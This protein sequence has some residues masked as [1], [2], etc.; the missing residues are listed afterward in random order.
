MRADR[1]LSLLMLLQARGR[2]TA[3]ELAKKLE[4]SERTVY[5]DMSALGMAGVPV[6]SERGPGGGCGLIEGY[7][8]NLTGLTETEV[9][10]LFMAGAPALLNDLGLGRS[11]EG[12]VLKLLAALPAA[13]RENVERARQRIH[14]DAFGWSHSEE[15]VP[16]LG[17]VQ[18]AVLRDRRLQITYRKGNGEV[19]ERL[20]DALGLV[21]KSTIWYLVGAVGGQARIFRIS[22]ILDATI[23]TDLCV[24]PQ[25][26][27]LAEYW[28]T[29]S[30][31]FSA[32]LSKYTV[33]VRIRSEAIPVLPQAVGD[34]ISP[35]IEQAG[36][37]DNDGAIQLTLTFESLEHA[38]SRMLSWGALM[39][40]LE[41]RE[42]R[43]SVI[44]FAMRTAAL[45][46]VERS[47]AFVLTLAAV[48]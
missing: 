41:P 31:E 20:V 33:V 21:A 1:L 46:A 34:W 12:A 35:L 23:T 38:R 14:I 11:L 15:P 18:D 17:A 39:E 16:F 5:R 10:T 48:Q 25:D 42:L 19:V 40:V 9:H 4:V 7:R 44:D 32:S 27:N 43:E 22:R 3:E 45:Y 36:E 37:P 26:F 13:Y 30:A 47:P 2:M 28:R 29:W 8:T 24:R 6:Y